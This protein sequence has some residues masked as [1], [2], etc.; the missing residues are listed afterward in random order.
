MAGSTAD[1]SL[2][3][4][5]DTYIGDLYVFLGSPDGI[6]T[7]EMTVD[8]CDVGDI[9]IP[10]TFTAGSTFEF[11]TVN[12]G[13]ILGEG[14]DGGNGG[15]DFGATGEAG[16]GG[17]NGGH[18]IRNEGNFATSLNIDD[19]FLFGGGGG[20]GGGSYTDTGTGGDAGNGG[21]GGQGWSGGAGGSGGPYSGLP[22]SV[23]GSAGSRVAAGDAGT[24]GTPVPGSTS[25][26]GNGG[27]WGLGGR[28][29]RSSNMV[30]NASFGSFFYHGGLGG[31]AGNAYFGP[32]PTL[33]GSETEADLRAAG[34]ILG[35]TGPDRLNTPFSFNFDAASTGIGISSNVG[36]TF[37]ADGSTLEINTGT[38]APPV[39]STVFYLKFGSGTGSDFEVRVSDRAGDIDGAFDVE[40]AAAGTWVVISTERSWYSTLLRQTRG[41]LFE[42]RRADIP[43]TTST[44]DEVMHSFYMKCSQE[45]A[46]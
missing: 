39:N 13:R 45:D 14:G 33:S 10:N 3:I 32:T 19:G 27:T 35:E 46:S 15:A 29:G 18:A 40:E 1:I 26:G 37:N 28:S 30:T 41:A 25:D 44:S 6:K 17:Q 2:T 12:G 31:D 20:G 4:T 23:N 42:I 22:A 16:D 24:Y 43:G 5:V 34:R 9:V 11:I 7:V 36:I 8:G 38:G 21:G